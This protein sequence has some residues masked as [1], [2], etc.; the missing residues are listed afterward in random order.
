MVQFEDIIRQ[1]QSYR[2]GGGS[3]A[4][5]SALTE[6]TGQ[7]N[8]PTRNA[9]PESPLFPIRWKSW[10]ILAG[11]KWTHLPWWLACCTM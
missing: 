8:T 11:M 4:S 7:T 9:Y 5:A 6:F 1:V 2:A 10:H 3:L